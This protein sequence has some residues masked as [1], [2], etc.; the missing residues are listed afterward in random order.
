MRWNQLLLQGRGGEEGEVYLRPSREAW[1]LYWCFIRNPVCFFPLSFYICSNGAGD[2]FPCLLAVVIWFSLYSACSSHLPPARPF[3]GSRIVIGADVGYPQEKKAPGSCL[4]VRGVLQARIPWHSMVEFF[5][6]FAWFFVVLCN[7]QP[8]AE[9]IRNHQ[10]HPFDPA[11]GLTFSIFFFSMGWAGCNC[12]S[13]SWRKTEGLACCRAQ[14]GPKT[15]D[16]FTIP[17]KPPWNPNL[18][19]YKNF[20]SP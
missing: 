2:L 1:R 12:T 13:L 14:F 3:K 11:V 10:L 16:Q 17:S 8:C 15:T 9:W 7:F 19:H 18:N 6:S 4:D 5:N 20:G